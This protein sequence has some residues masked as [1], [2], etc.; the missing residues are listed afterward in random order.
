M[1]ECFEDIIVVR[2]KI[3]RQGRDGWGES[4]EEEE[5]EDEHSWDR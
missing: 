3:M 5:E 2:M 1:C 4:N